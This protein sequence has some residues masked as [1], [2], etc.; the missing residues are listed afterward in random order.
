[1][2]Y[3]EEDCALPGHITYQSSIMV[4]MMVMVVVIFLGTACLFQGLLQE[5]ISLLH[6]LDGAL[7]IFGNLSLSFIT[8]KL[9]PFET[10][11]LMAI[12][13]FYPMRQKYFQLFQFFH[14]IQ[15]Y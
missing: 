13:V 12:V 5:C 9:R 4:V 8:G 3:R 6:S 11:R 2:V 10:F 7:D 1:M 15:P 14:G